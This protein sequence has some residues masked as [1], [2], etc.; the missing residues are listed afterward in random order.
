MSAKV[1]IVGGG[2]IGL[3]HA[4]AF[5]Y[6]NPDLEIVVLEKYAKYQRIHTLSMLTEFFEDLM[7]A[8]ETTEDP[9]LS[10]LLKQLKENSSISTS[11]LEGIFKSLAENRGVRVIH[12]EVKES[13]FEEAVFK[14][15]KII[16]GADGTHS[17]VNQTFFP[18]GNHQKHENDFALQL[19]FDI[20]GKAKPQKNNVID[21]VQGMARNGVIATEH[22]GRIV[23]GKKPVT[24]Q[25]IIPKAVYE[26]FK[27]ATSKYPVRYLEQD[28]S[29]QIPD[30]ELTIDEL[31]EN[32]KTFINTFLSQKIEL[33]TR[34][35]DQLDSDTV[36][37]SV[38]ELPAIRA[39]QVV[40]LDKEHDRQIVLVGD[41]GLALSYFMGLNAGIKATA[42]FMTL[43][44]N[45]IKNNFDDREELD[46]ALQK[47]QEWMLKDFGPKKVKDVA[48]Y[49]TLWVKGPELV[50][51]VSRGLKFASQAQ[52]NPTPNPALKAYLKL[53]KA[54]KNP[55]TQLNTRR[56]NL[57]LYPHRDYEPVQL[58]Q[59][60]QVPIRHTLRK[61]WKLFIS[62]FQPYRSRTQAIQDFKQPLVGIVNL[63][64]G[65]W[66]V[67]GGIVTLNP[68]R[69]IDG[70]FRFIRGALEILTTPLAWLIKPLTRGFIS[71]INYLIFGLPKIEN[72]G[73]LKRI[74]SLGEELLANPE[75][76]KE[77]IREE[78]KDG[79]ENAREKELDE[80]EGKEQ[81][82]LEDLVEKIYIYKATQ[83]CHDLHRKSTNAL[84]KGQ[85]TDIQASELLYY[86]DVCKQATPKNLHAY[87][88]LFS[89]RGV[90]TKERDAPEVDGSLAFSSGP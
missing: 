47:Y 54:A 69:S 16:M 29:Q 49:S 39:Q 75:K 23:D 85:A 48:N 37:I 52:Y 81:D 34:N 20:L 5:K 78:L 14:D 63:W 58:G 59:F 15:A 62:Y 18:E 41:A 28:S 51:K 22:I 88:S 70:L 43:L 8:T 9:V 73:G 7:I 74:A 79:V 36:R 17:V 31:P 26:D 2:P 42:T 1:V 61:I 3:A 87:F 45:C 83:V 24:V 35:G 76:E 12:E 10:T 56:Y 55:L 67:L 21:F 6:L 80:E 72:N 33:C 30:Q 4:W 32:L 65:F 60:K 57:R 53:L 66:K 44:K 13:S 50:V 40:T 90:K 82:S 38:N 77:K 27:A 46:E 25:I 11:E 68:V 84:K 64:V 71:L 89:H 86:T 19:R